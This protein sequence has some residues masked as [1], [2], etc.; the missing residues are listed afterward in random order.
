MGRTRSVQMASFA[1]LV[2]ANLS[3]FFFRA[4]TQ[5]GCCSKIECRSA[6]GLHSTEIV[7]IE[8]QESL[9]AIS[10]EILEND[11]EPTRRH[12]ASANEKFVPTFKTFYRI[13]RW[14]LYRTNTNPAIDST[15]PIN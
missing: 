14:L 10:K 12:H 5:S 4:S 3:T 13:S 15:K 6:K 11:W 2:R 9:T 8:C 1:C 7:S